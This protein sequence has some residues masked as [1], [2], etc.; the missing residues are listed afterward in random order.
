MT[1]AWIRELLPI[2]IFAL[3]VLLLP[4]Y[5][6]ILWPIIWKKRSALILRHFQGK[7]IYPDGKLEIPYSSALFRIDRNSRGAGINNSVGGSFPSLWTY[8]CQTPKFILGNAL[9]GKYTIGNFLILPTHETVDIEGF[10][11]LMGS[12]SQEFKERIRTVLMENPALTQKLGKL[13]QKEWAHLTIATENHIKNFWIQR[14]TVLRYM[15]LPEEIYQQP[16]ILEPIL[17]TITDFVEKLGISFD[18]SQS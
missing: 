3:P 5:I 4:T 13:F 8:T 17:Q 6:F 9:S 14:R 2:A 18:P 16:E 12:K 7:F 11:F 10:S 15:A 1:R